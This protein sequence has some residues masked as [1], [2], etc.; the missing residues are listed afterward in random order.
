M[1]DF[2]FCLA[3]DGARD[4]NT[5]DAITMLR[6]SRDYLSGG[7]DLTP[8]ARAYLIECHDNFLSGVAEQDTPVKMQRHFANAFNLTPPKGKP[9]NNILD[10]YQIAN[11]I[12][13]IK[14][15]DKC[16][17]EDAIEIYMADNPAFAEQ[18]AEG[19]IDNLRRIYYKNKAV[20][21]IHDAQRI[22]NH[23]E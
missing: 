9:K 16:S 7:S 6:L 8:D 4:K 15:R 11:D 17:L 21:D 20:L 3:V 10:D 13:A 14:Q 22:E 2:P 5:Q 1:T 23:E 18:A 19:R 12:H